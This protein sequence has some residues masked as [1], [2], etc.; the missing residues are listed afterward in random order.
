MR[1]DVFSVDNR[2]H[3]GRI[4]RVVLRVNKFRQKN[5]TMTNKRCI[6]TALKLCVGLSAFLSTSALADV[7]YDN[8]ANDLNFRFRPGTLEVGDEIILSGGAGNYLTKFSFEFYGT[9]GL[10]GGGAFSGPV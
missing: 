2:D 8:T 10:P 4:I 3:A 5:T 9:N 6:I 7:V 1:K